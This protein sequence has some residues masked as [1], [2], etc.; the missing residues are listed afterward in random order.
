M[1]RKEGGQVMK[2][3]KEEEEERNPIEQLFWNMGIWLAI[4]LLIFLCSLVVV[5]LISGWPDSGV[6]EIEP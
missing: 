1:G 3:I 2:F 5:H 6:V 4:S